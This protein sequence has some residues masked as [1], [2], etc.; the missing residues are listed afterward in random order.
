MG[1]RQVSDA[2]NGADEV[3]KA[4]GIKPSLIILDLSMPVMNELEAA[5]ALKIQP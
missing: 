5:R 1:P 3:Q 2:V 4:Q